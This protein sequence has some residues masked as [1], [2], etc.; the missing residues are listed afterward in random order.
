MYV[1]IGAPQKKAPN[2]LLQFPQ[3]QDYA[4]TVAEGD[5]ALDRNNDA[6]TVER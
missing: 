5:D 1:S 3:L 2:H 6:E 4:A